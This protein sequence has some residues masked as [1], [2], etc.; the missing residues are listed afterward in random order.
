MEYFS[1]L[2]ESL[3]DLKSVFVFGGCS[4][5]TESFPDFKRRVVGNKK[6]GEKGF[7]VARQPSGH[8]WRYGKEAGPACFPAGSQTGPRLCVSPAGGCS[9]TN[10]HFTPLC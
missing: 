8:C 7:I 1:Q 3:S 4:A 2:N 9:G 10:G 5:Q 6:R